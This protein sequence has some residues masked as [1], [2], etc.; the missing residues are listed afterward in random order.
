MFDPVF[1]LSGKWKAELHGPDGTL[2]DVKIGS[3]VI[4]TNG[5]EFLASYL[6]SA[7]A[8]AATFTMRYIAIGTDSTAEA[9]GNTSLGVE[10]ARHTGVVSYISGQIYQVKATFAAGTGTGAIVEYGLLSSSTAGT[11]LARDTES[12]INKGAGDTLT[13]TAQITIS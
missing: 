4:C 8:A 2:K 11:L 12:V 1:K 6:Q 13:V 3:N 9:A 7:A 10:V 5:K